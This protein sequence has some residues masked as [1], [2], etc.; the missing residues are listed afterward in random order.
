MLAAKINTTKAARS[1]VRGHF[2]GLSLR[3]STAM[4]SPL[5]ISLY[6]FV[7][8]FMFL[9]GICLFLR[10]LGR[11]FGA[12]RSRRRS[13]EWQ[14]AP[15]DGRAVPPSRGLPNFVPPPTP[16]TEQEYWQAEQYCFENDLPAPLPPPRRERDEW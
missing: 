11:I 7:V 1:C 14:P 13:P 4:H 2:G 5:F 16:R 15:P 12:D 9:G 8:V 3:H 10:I 6:A